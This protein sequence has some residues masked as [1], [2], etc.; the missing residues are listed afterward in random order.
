MTEKQ[1]LPKYKIWRHMSYQVQESNEDGD[2]F[3]LWEET[4]YPVWLLVS[5]L[6]LWILKLPICLSHLSNLKW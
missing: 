1:N 4:V 2:D 5:W 6:A 3:S